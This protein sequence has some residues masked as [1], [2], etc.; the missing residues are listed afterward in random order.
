VGD[1]CGV[2]LDH[3]GNRDR[4]AEAPGL[5]GDGGNA[6]ARNGLEGQRDGLRELAF[7][8]M[9]VVPAVLILFAFVL[10]TVLGVLSGFFT[11]VLFTVLGMLSGFFTGV[12]VSVLCVLLALRAVL[13]VSF[14]GR[15]A[16]GE[17]ER[18]A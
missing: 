3:S 10:F 2:D 17:D 14:T 15:C 12:L 16:P 11:G 18:D 8:L 5:D 6:G 13:V 1:A 4:A 9:L 7:A